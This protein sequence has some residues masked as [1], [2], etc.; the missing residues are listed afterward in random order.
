MPHDWS[1][2]VFAAMQD[3]E[4]GTVCTVPDAG[5]SKLL[6]RSEDDPG[7]RV[8][9]LSTEEEGIGIAMGLWLGG[10]RSLIAMQSSGVGNT[11]NAL[12]LPLT[13]RA[14]CLMLIT[15]RGEWGE[16]NPW[17]VPMGRATPT[18]LEAMGVHVFR[19]D[20]AEEV[21]E[22]FIAAADLALN[23]NLSAAVLVGQRAIGAK[24]F[25][26]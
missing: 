12:G 17:Q 5:L 19:A 26:K 20:R 1:G 21:G 6:I 25:G 8:V 23:G 2:E 13:L 15:M 11:I 18:V 24:G 4:I 14:P 9:T 16:V 10:K 7:T 22:T 3:R